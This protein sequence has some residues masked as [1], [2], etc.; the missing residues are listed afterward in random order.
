[1]ELGIYKH[2]RTQNLYNVIRIGRRVENP[3]KQVVIYEQLYE[4]K[5]REENIDLPKGS[6]WDRDLDDFKAK[7]VYVSKH[8]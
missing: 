6:T 2:I 5:L 1:M 4:S 3:T 8:L 7:F